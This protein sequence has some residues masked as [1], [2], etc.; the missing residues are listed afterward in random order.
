MTRALQAI[1]SFTNGPIPVDW[2][3]AEET[4]HSPETLDAAVGK[5]RGAASAAP[6]SGA[7][8]EAIRRV[9]QGL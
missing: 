1:V 5:R 6:A 4:P 8:Q 9:D 3:R 2:E 7:R